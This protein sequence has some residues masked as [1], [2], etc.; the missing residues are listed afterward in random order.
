[1]PENSVW[2][3]IHELSNK[4]GITEIMINGPGQVFIE[5]D[6]NFIQLAVSIS[7]SD[8]NDFVEE[9]ATYNQKVC[10]IT[11]PMLDGVLPDGSRINVV[12]EPFS[13]DFPAVPP[14]IKILSLA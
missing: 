4:V 12:L 13:R 9:V 14:V 3:L 7:K 10:D 6:G 11:D 8:L 2:K 1:M 5:K